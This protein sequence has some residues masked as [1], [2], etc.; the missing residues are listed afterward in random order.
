[1]TK[2][3]SFSI[4]LDRV[5]NSYNFS[6]LL[7]NAIRHTPSFVDLLLS[8]GAS[9]TDPAVPRLLHRAA[10]TSSPEMVA[11]LLDFGMPTNV[12]TDWQLDAEDWAHRPVLQYCP[13]HYAVAHKRPESFDCCSNMNGIGQ[14]AFDVE[15]IRG[16]YTGPKTSQEFKREKISYRKKLSEMHSSL[17]NHTGLQRAIRS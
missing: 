11:H 2:N 4:L 3:S 5:S 13:L 15:V 14:P 17:L 6:I 7:E 8:R 10:L 12:K 1:M 16:C 9:L